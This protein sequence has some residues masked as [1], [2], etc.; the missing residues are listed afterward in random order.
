MTTT[1]LGTA[2]RRARLGGIALAMRPYVMVIAL[3]VIWVVNHFL[4]SGGHFITPR[5]LTL[6][7]RQ[8]SIMGIAATG[9]F[10]VIVMGQI[11]L[12]VGSVAVLCATVAGYLHVILGWN[13]V[14]AMLIALVVGVLI[15]ALQ[16]FAVAYLG[17]PSFIVTLGGLLFWRGL[18]L[19][20]TGGH[21]ISPIGAAFEL[22]GGEY[23]PTDIASIVIGAC[24]LIY[25]AVVVVRAVQRKRRRLPVSVAETT[26][27]AVGPLVVAAAMIFYL[28]RYKGL[29][30]PVITLALLVLVVGFISRNTRFGRH[31]YAVG[32][33]RE[34]AALAGID[35]ARVTLTTFA[36]AGLIYAIAGLVLAGRMGAAAPNMGVFLELEVIASCVI[37]GTSL[38][39]GAGSVI[40][41]L[42]GALVMASLDN[43]LALNFALSPYW[44]FIVK[45]WVLILAVWFDIA[46]KRIRT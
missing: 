15:G 32:G 28:F 24:S 14:I 17:V 3:S 23:V 22:L 27:S 46:T 31:L 18:H 39:G 13:P 20:I 2:V 26:F 12:S 11:D 43:G 8:M 25:L 42:V 44:K 45:G 34:A 33:N 16:G 37:G 36:V 41:A 5:N 30:T 9:M 10:M 6:L 29:P 1:E 7:L 21:S 4:I 19:V 35:V 40:G 38:L